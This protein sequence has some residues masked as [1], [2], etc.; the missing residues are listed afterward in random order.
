MDRNNAVLRQDFWFDNLDAVAIFWLLAYVRDAIDFEWLFDAAG[1]LNANNTSPSFMSR[2]YAAED[3]ELAG[4]ILHMIKIRLVYTAEA[5]FVYM[6]DGQ[7]K[8]FKAMKCPAHYKSI[9][10]TAETWK[11]CVESFGMLAADAGR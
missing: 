7:R 6:V 1:H 2:L 3:R 9:A 10:A 11:E 8:S 5:V 4:D